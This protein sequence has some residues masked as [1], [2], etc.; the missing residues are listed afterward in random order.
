MV[1][2]DFFQHSFSSI[3]LVALL[4]ALLQVAIN[5]SMFMPQLSSSTFSDLTSV[6]A[7]SPSADN[8]KRSL[9][10]AH[11]RFQCPVLNYCRIKFI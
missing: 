7:F 4:T 9:S 2:Q 3:S 1:I 11:G 6:L 10:P 5:V 8:L